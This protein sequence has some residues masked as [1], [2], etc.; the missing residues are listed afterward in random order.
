MTRGLVILAAGGTGG[1]LFPAFALAEALGRRD[2]VV[3]LVTD[4]RGDR[5]GTGFPARTI[6]Q[7]PAATLKDRSPVGA[8]RTVAALARGVKRAYA[9]LG[10]L[11]PKVVVGFGGYPTF[12]PIVAARLRGIPTL[13]HEQNA[14]MGRA[15]RMLIGRVTAVAASWEGTGHVPPAALAKVRVTGNPVRQA[16]I[17]WSRKRFEPPAADGPFRLVVFGGSQGARYFSDTVPVALASLSPARRSRLRVVQ[18][19]REEDLERVR[20][21]YREAGIAAE[22]AAFFRD[23]P[24]RMANAHLVIARSGASS[25]SE[26]AVLGRPSLL[27]PLPHSIDNDQLMNA[28]RLAE[29]GGAIAIEQKDLSSERLAAE[30]ARLMDDGTGLAAMAAGARSLGR[31]DAVEALADLVEDL[32]GLR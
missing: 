4:E 17:D 1:H 32:A 31:P 29:A 30:I 16:V 19:C 27:V 15:N 26:L 2:L 25:V 13:I 28:R 24:E 9:I 11:R 20:G 22:L 10:E 18:Q 21:F 3:D 8:A 5:Y 14:V 12:P 7:V 6:H 23:L